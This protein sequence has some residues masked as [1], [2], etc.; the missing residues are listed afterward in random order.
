MT[1]SKDWFRSATRALSFQW[2]VP[3]FMAALPPEHLKLVENRKRALP[4]EHRVV[5][6]H[7]SQRP[8][9][10]A[11]KAYCELAA[12]AGVPTE[13]VPEYDCGALI[14]GR[15]APPYGSIVGL[16]RFGIPLGVY[17]GV[18]RGPQDRW[19]IAGQH[20]YSVLDYAPLP[21]PVPCR[22]QLGLWRVPE[23][24]RLPEVRSLRWRASSGT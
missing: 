12:R 8:S 3:L 6:M 23:D 13:L 11:F 20:G 15:V 18:V 17:D 14:K 10:A 5:W 22:G 21:E 4:L 16:L 7:V 2:P 9:R 19:R 24:I 1:L